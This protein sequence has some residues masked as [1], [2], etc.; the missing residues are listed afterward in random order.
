M[1]E[2]FIAL[3]K[4]IPIDKYLPIGT[5][6][7]VEN[8]KKDIMIVGYGAFEETTNQEKPTIYDYCGYLYPE[9][10][11]GDENTLIFNHD[12]IKK[13]KHKG[14]TPDNYSQINQEIT[15]IINNNQEG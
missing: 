10:Y 4:Y 1:E 5:I 11:S 3:E 9:G 14:Y 12:K 7:E 6:V 8:V 15:N 13:V 2:N